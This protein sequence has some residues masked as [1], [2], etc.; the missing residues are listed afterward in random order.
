MM[1][2]QKISYTYLEDVI[3]LA[4]TVYQGPRP[5]SSRARS[6]MLTLDLDELSL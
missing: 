1:D 3:A 4:C 6:V 5:H 2:L